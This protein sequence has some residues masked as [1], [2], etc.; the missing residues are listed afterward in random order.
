M[1]E[2]E[3]NGTFDFIPNLDPST[4][5]S[6]DIYKSRVEISDQTAD[7][8]SS[9]I[10]RKSL[11]ETIGGNQLTSS[12]LSNERPL[13]QRKHSPP[14]KRKNSLEDFELEIEGINLDDN[15]DVSVNYFDFLIKFVS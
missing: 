4:I 3:A 13:Q 2:A 14:I 1:N 7:S 12:I 5:I 11:T 6:N 9:S 15:I 8:N 10:P